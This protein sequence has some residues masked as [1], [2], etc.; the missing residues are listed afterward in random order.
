MFLPPQKK[1]V[2]KRRN[3]PQKKS[4]TETDPEVLEE[5]WRVV[6]E[7]LRAAGF[8]VVVHHVDTRGRIAASAPLC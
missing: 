6:S 3:R 4:T 7:E 2:R 8:Q 5:T 1:K